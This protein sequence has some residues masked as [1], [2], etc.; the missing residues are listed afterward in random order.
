MAL[1]EPVERV[2]A[3]QQDGVPQPQNEQQIRWGHS[4]QLSQRA[5]LL[6][7]LRRALSSSFNAPE[8]AYR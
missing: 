3:M 1:M 2:S 4:Q 7:P 5:S 8:S 6:Q